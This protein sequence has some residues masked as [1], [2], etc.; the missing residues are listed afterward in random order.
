MSRIVIVI[1]MYHRHK[2]TDLTDNVD[3]QRSNYFKVRQNYVCMFLT[4]SDVPAYITSLVSLPYQEL[5]CHRYAVSR[6]AY[7]LTTTWIP[8]YA[9]S[10]C[11]GP[12]VYLL[13]F[14]FGCRLLVSE[15]RAAFQN[16]RQIKQVSFRAHC[17][18]TW[19][20]YNP[21]DLYRLAFMNGFAL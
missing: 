5:Q 3:E 20:M 12:N 18:L 4:R 7:L 1:L 6:T 2:L 16:G 11:L 8:I 10:L 21:R 13:L 19:Y 17:E 15:P 14:S 9:I